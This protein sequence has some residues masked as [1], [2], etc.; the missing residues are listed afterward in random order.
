MKW[1]RQLF[2]RRRL[3]SDLSEEI[4]AH[5]E[6]KIAELVENGMPR[7]QAEYVARR[8]FGNVTLLEERSREVWQW[9]ILESLFQDM[10][11]SLRLM[12][13]NPVFTAVAVLSLAF[14]IGANTALFS[15]LDSLVLRDLQVPQPEQ[16][17]SVGVHTPDDSSSGLSLP[18][19]K[20]IVRAQKVFSAVFAWWGDAVLN[21]EANG[22]L[23]R[24]DV[25][26][27][28]G[29]YY[30]E[31]GATPKIGR[32]IAPDD[33]DL[34]SAAPVPAQV[35][36]L[37]YA[38]WQRNYGRAQDV[39]GK[40]IRVEGVLFTIIGVAGKGF[41]GISPEL[42]ADVTVPITAEPLLRGESD[43]Q[44]RL[45]RPDSLWLEAAGRLKP[46]VTIE[47]A[48]A[49]L[50]SVWPSIRRELV[51]SGRTAL[52]LGNFLSLKLKIESGAKGGS[53]LRS[54]FVKP[55]F[56]LLAIA[57]LVLLIACVN[58]AG[59]ML[60]RGAAR[61][62]EIGVRVAL[63]ASRAR[64]THQMLTESATLSIAGALAAF[65][66][67]YSG[68]RTLSS[69]MLGELFIV[70]VQLNL[71]PDWR[72]IS[73]TACA[74]ILTT[75]LF[76]WTPAWRAG[77]EDPN[78]AVQQ[79]GRAL[80]R[81]T[82]RLSKGFVVAQVALSLVLLVCAG[83]FIRSLE[84]LRAANPGF[85]A[86]GLL[87][88]SLFPKPGGYKNVDWASYYREL[89]ERISNLPGVVSAALI[90]GG[91]GQPVE[92]SEKVR[93]NGA[94]AKGIR[95][96][97]AMVMPGT[98]RTL[99][100]GLLHGRGFTWQDDGRAPR[101]VIVSEDFAV[102]RFPKGNA[103]GQR[104]DITLGPKWQNLQ[105][106]GVVSNASLYDM[107]KHQVPT[108]YLPTTQYGDFM[109]YPFLL[110]ETKI[111]P[112]GLAIPLRRTVESLGREY[113]I[114]VKTIEQNIARTLLQERL[115]AMLSALLGGLALVLSAIGLYGLMAYNVTRRSRE[116][117]I[118]M[119]LG[120]QQSAVQWMILRET[121]VFALTGL[122][123]G[124]PCAA[125][126]TRLIVSMLY[127]VGTND[128]ITILAVSF[129]LLAVAALAGFI[130]A[131]RAMRLDP[132]ATLHHE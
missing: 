11:H 107:R 96:D 6:E 73:F 14:G 117:G 28:T 26:A 36:V 106:V 94:G 7:S 116:I 68:S 55:L 79:S 29:N 27:V 90:H 19:L 22:V 35:A 100:I 82:V 34:N 66:L 21:V 42:A 111:S 20:E 105:I 113:I 75:M 76:G 56:V 9:Q 13:R 109:G 53:F 44:K 124:L 61:H 69:F 32:L 85:R 121:L 51:P 101:I 4:H 99:G 83:L 112:A 80:T 122:I 16:L 72:I 41:T 87:S 92:W 2:A 103:I 54:R 84:K 64:L 125:A 104:L 119:A 130:P 67:A 89:N 93:M 37:G 115:T 97:I 81:N 40:T 15:L 17:V 10:Q 48:R 95:A 63:G 50:E 38:F 131:R 39:I 25:W 12:L 5:L 88:V 118:R 65:G 120:A 127:G 71:S 126:A 52:E 102:Q 98:L 129:L 3:Y 91:P 30:S 132:I 46:G 33:V 49:Q 24:A 110:I 114:Q 18:M 23:S 1:I 128:P 108:V 45:R 78:R 58:L 86:H 59:L 123:I 74:A 70:P 62:Y 43:M 31:L 77:R 57:G 60:A 47:Q 8:D